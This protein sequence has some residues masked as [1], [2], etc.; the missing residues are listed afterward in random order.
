MQ[1]HVYY[2]FTVLLINV[3]N[4]YLLL[5]VFI[6]FYIFLLL[7]GSDKHVISLKFNYLN[8]LHLS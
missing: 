5:Y 8:H 7:K 1:L 2:R 6:F 4:L 3:S